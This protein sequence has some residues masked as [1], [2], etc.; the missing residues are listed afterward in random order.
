[1]WDVYYR[2]R[3]DGAEASP[4]AAVVGVGS[5]PPMNRCVRLKGRD[6]RSDDYV[7]VK[8]PGSPF[9]YSGSEGDTTYVV[10]LDQKAK[11]HVDSQ[12]CRI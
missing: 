9:R 10:N 11:V 7:L 8:V 12:A 1:M 4:D 3:V 5:A 2:I 6:V